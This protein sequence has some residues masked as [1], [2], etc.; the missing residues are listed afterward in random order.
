MEVQLYKFNNT[1]AY[2]Q[3][4]N[5]C[6]IYALVYQN[7]VIYVGQSIDVQHRLYAHH[8]YKSKI[9]LYEQRTSDSSKNLYNFYTFLQE[10]EDDVYF[11]VIPTELEKLNEEEEKYIKKYQPKYN[12]SGVRIAYSPVERFQQPT[13]ADSSSIGLTE[14][15]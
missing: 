9:K 12:W 5:I 14:G 2:S 11:L 13:A 1:K 10:H 8:G 7:T 4:K 15:E 3:Y 6:G